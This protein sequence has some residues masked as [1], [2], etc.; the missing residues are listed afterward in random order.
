M[1]AAA[2]TT[3]FNYTWSQGL[4][5]LGQI[6][7]IAALTGFMLFAIVTDLVFPRL[8]GSGVVAMVAVTGYAYS[9]ATAAYRWAYATGGPAYNGTAS[10]DG[11]ALFFEML[12][13]IL[14]ILTVAISH[15]YLQKRSLRE[16]EVHILIMAAVIGMMVVGAATSLVTVF[17]GLELFSIALY[18]SCGFARTDSKSQEA[19]AKY[20]LVGG[21]A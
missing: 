19:A 1:I 13:A 8:R 12:F 5:D 10:G 21:F 11:F 17:L 14:G 20:L 2:A 18:I 4:A 15:S 3:T 9:L 7:P 16:S 6:S